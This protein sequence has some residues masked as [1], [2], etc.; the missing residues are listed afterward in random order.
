[1]HRH[2]GGVRPPIRLAPRL[3]LALA[4]A[5]VFFAGRADAQGAPVRIDEDA[6]SVPSGVLR[7]GISTDFEYTEKLRLPDGKQVPLARRLGFD[8][9]T[10]NVVASSAVSI[11]RLRLALDYGVTRWLAI[12]ASAPLVR[13]RVE[14]SADTNVL[15]APLTSRKKRVTDF[16]ALTGFTRTNVGD[17]DFTARIALFDNTRRGAPLRLRVAAEGGFRLA[18]GPSRSVNSMLDPGAGDG[19]NDVIA[20]VFADVALGGRWSVAA[21]ASRTWQ[22]QDR[23]TILLADSLYPSEQIRRGVARDLGDLTAIMIAPRYRLT[24]YIQFAASAS[25]LTKTADRY[26]GA[27]P[28]EG[29][30]LVA[31][32]GGSYGITRAGLGIVF[33]TMPNGGAVG[34]WPAEIV[35]EHSQIVHS[36]GAAVPDTRVDRLGGRLYIKLF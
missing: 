11:T 32:P 28:D 2:G 5:S 27:V 21:A 24:R 35:F 34:S 14:A 8:S 3:A 31:P 19:Q 22:R 10:D 17:I 9:T 29:W 30:G 12:G 4:I 1:M 18:A 36:S 26:S 16:S 20:A 33:S 15:Q 13:R 25:Q 23:Q 7:V 6:R